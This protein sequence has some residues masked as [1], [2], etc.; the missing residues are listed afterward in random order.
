M[1][2]ELNPM[3]ICKIFDSWEHFPG[4]GNRTQI[5]KRKISSPALARLNQDYLITLGV[6]ST[7]SLSSRN[8]PI[9]IP[10]AETVELR[11]RLKL[12]H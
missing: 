3:C 5:F 12:H 1:A 10:S 4:Y 11:F 2:S 6:K 8:L 7:L 9:P